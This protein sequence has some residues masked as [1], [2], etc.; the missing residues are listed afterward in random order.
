MKKN[1]QQ[2]IQTAVFVSGVM[3]AAQL[4]AAPFYRF[5]RG[6]KKAELSKE[7]FQ[8]AIAKTFVSATVEYG[9]GKSLIAYIPAIPQQIEDSANILIPDEVAL[10]VYDSKENY[11]ALRATPMGK[12]YG[13]LHWN[14]FVRAP[15]DPALPVPANASKSA[16]PEAFTEN[17]ILENGKAYD[18]LQSTP[19]WQKGLVKVRFLKRNTQEAE[20]IKKI[21]SDF[22]AKA[23]GFLILADI[24]YLMT[25]ELWE[26]SETLRNSQYENFINSNFEYQGKNNLKIRNTPYNLAGMQ[27]LRISDGKGLNARFDVTKKS[28]YVESVKA[29]EFISKRLEEIEASFSTFKS[30]ELSYNNDTEDKIH[31]VYKVTYDDENGIPNATHKQYFEFK[32][33]KTVLSPEGMM[34]IISN[35]EEQ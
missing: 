27:K 23:Q 31:R 8:K 13:D 32:L 3:G 28:E 5:W 18:L 9:A 6:Y 35:G 11:E 16:V 25:Y 30:T 7:D 10:V 26:S 33:A 34:L 19:Q 15:Q 14:Y 17:T 24:N 12:A 20:L 22:A 1:F 4:N 2:I 21:K 29:E